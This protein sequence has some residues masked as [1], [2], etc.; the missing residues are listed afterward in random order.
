SG[1]GASMVTVSANTTPLVTRSTRT[2]TR[3]PGIAPA[4]RTTWPFARASMRPP[5]AGFSIVNGN[6]WLGESIATRSLALKA[7]APPM[8]ALMESNRREPE[9]H[10]HEAIHHRVARARE[11][12]RGHP[13][14]KAF[15]LLE[16]LALQGRAQGL[17]QR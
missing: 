4:T 16:R 12:L 15:E 6:V 11:R 2:V 7:R 1:D 10:A 8:S 3:S 5:A 13:R 9:V 14:A 17:F